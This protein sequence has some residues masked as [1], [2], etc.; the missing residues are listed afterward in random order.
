MQVGQYPRERAARHAANWGWILHSAWVVYTS[1][2]MPSA[3]ATATRRWSGT[4]GDHALERRLAP[5]QWDE[6]RAYNAE[7]GSDSESEAD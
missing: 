7:Y 2:E 6:V 5:W 3:R 1:F 4:L